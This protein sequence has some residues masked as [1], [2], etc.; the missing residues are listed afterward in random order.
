MTGPSPLVVFRADADMRIG[1]GH[2]MRCLTL[3]DVLAQ[4][5]CVCTLMS[6]PEAPRVV[7]ALLTTR[8][9]LVVTSDEPVEAAAV[10]FDHYGI[11]R[12]A[13]RLWRGHADKIVVIDDL[14]DRPHECDVLIDQ[15]Y[16]IDADR[17]AAL[18]PSHC[19]I[20]A[21]VEFAL[22]R[23]QFSRT[24][25]AAL[26]RRAQW[27]GCPRNVMLSL[28]LTDIGGH[29]AAI[30]EILLQT[31]GLQRLEVIIGPYSLSE[32]RLSELQ[33]SDSRLTVLKGIEN[34]A[35]AMLW[36]DIAVGALGTSTWERCALGLPTIG[37][38]LADNQLAIAAA[39]QATDAAIV[40]GDL[41]H[42][43]AS[44]L[45]ARLDD[46]LGD[47]ERLKRV[48]K[49][50]AALCDGDGAPRVADAVLSGSR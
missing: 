2:V 23:P 22:L 38:T 30:A 5:G 34:M 6:N 19:R 25:E 3:A 8:H 9:N 36:A 31:R 49:I 43:S 46:S 7:P 47:P 50:C 18:V 42:L 48:S 26:A 12:G 37:L 13:E 11:D 1:G 24:R 15:N 20:L 32:T 17:Y 29:S 45:K 33:A 28:G 40:I 10:V 16:A 41:R 27:D 4:R 14:A 44:A 35:E 21:G 39:L